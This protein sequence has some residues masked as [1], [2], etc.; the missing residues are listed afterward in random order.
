M[1]LRLRFLL[2]F[3]GTILLGLTSRWAPIRDV[4]GTWLGD[5]LYAVMIFFLWSALFPKQALKRRA[6]FAL[7]IC[8]TIEFLQLFQAEWMLNLR[9]TLLGSLVLGHG[10]LWSDIALYTLGVLVVLGIT[11]WV[12]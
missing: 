5:V 12:K 8:Y 6:L 9:A 3:F 2:L 4:I 10:F 7:L 11:R 1:H